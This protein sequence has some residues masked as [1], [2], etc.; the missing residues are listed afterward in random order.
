[1][2]RQDYILRLI[3]QAAAALARAFAA[4]AGKQYDMALAEL[5][6][7]FNAASKLDRRSFDALDT[8]TVA[9]LLG[10]PEQLRMV[11]RVLAAEAEVH[12][13][14]GNR[15]TARRCLQRARE[16]LL[17]LSELTPED[18]LALADVGV[19][20]RSHAAPGRG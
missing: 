16:L 12:E 20:L 9:R 17:E 19:R 1:M 15:L 8:R 7:A 11:A 14:Q 18:Q 13:Q 5:S 6:Q 4:L 10:S 3:E 2:L